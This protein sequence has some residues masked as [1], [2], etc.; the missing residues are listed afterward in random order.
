M[1][2][3]LKSGRGFKIYKKGVTSG[4]T[5]DFGVEDNR[6]RLA[7]HRCE[8]DKAHRVVFNIFDFAIFDRN[9]NSIGFQG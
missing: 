1:L 8:F 7:A 5:I 6:I 9:L 3:F 4:V 2:N